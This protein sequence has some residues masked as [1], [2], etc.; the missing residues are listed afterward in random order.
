M[1]EPVTQ[2]AD[3]R[4]ALQQVEAYDMYHTFDY[5]AAQSSEESS[6]MLLTYRQSGHLIALP[7]LRRHV[8]ALGAE[9]G[10]ALTDFTSVYGYGGIVASPGAGQAATGF[11]EALIRW[12]QAE[13][14]VSVFT[15]LHPL[16]ET[17]HMLDA[18]GQ[19]RAV[20]TTVSI[21]L[22]ASEEE[23]IGRYRKQ[24][25]YDLRRLRQAGVTATEL[26][27]EAGLD[28]FLA[29]YTETM[30]RL[31]A[32]Q[33]YYFSREYFRSMLTASDYN[34]VIL[35]AEFEGE[36]VAAALFTECR[37][38]AQYHLSGVVSRALSQSP[39]R[40]LLDEGR[41]WAVARGAAQLHLGGGLGGQEDLLFRFKAGFSPD[42]HK[43]EVWRWVP[44]EPL[45]RQVCLELGRLDSDSFF[46]AYRAPLPATPAQ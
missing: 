46:P 10:E 16:I 18:L 23:Q 37:G 34:T 30:D 1:I 36:L 40:L 39:T 6:P 31:N 19:C 32:Q 42:R 24:N 44:N 22:S 13:Q 5:H 8:H 20:G 9:A 35:G 15:R 26:N 28:A 4:S 14:V 2:A 25:R 43:F 45:Y 17:G 27:G 33:N 38:I 29:I 21:D 11:R 41:R 12:A 7:L 3:W